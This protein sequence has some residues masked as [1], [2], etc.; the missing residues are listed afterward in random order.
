MAEKVRTEPVDFGVVC[1][2]CGLP[3]AVVNT[4]AKHWAASQARL[5]ATG[6]D[7]LDPVFVDSSARKLGMRTDAR[8]ALLTALACVRASSLL[9]R[10]ARHCRYLLY[11][12]PG[13]LDADVRLWPTLPAELGPGAD[14]LYA[15]VFLAGLPCVERLHRERGVPWEITLDTL[16][17]LELWIREHRR[18]HGVWGFSEHKWLIHHVSATLFKIGRLQFQFSRFA[19]PFLAFRHVQTGEVVVFAGDGTEWRADGQFASADGGVEREGAR[20]AR[21]QAGGEWLIGSCVAPRGRALL[22]SVRLPASEWAEILRQ[23]DRTMAVHIP[24]GGRLDHELCGHS[25]ASAVA[26]FSEHYP[27]YVF[28]AFTCGSWFLDPQFEDHLPADS[29]IVKFMREVYL[30]PIPNAGDGATFA[31]V[32]GEKPDDL[33][34]LP[35]DTAMQRAIVRH[36]RNGGRWRGGGCLLFPEDLRWGQQVYRRGDRWLPCTRAQRSPI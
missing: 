14:M 32:F 36:A 19:Y 13:A 9:Q 3:P 8:E 21:F 4:W 11:E 10:V 27:E 16:S 33:G 17:D 1:K 18:K 28:R 26:F 7:F 25:F 20:A 23:G 2:R 34:T 6:P 29:N 5:G 30:I 22:D 31:R 15:F 12:S 35:Q 24:A